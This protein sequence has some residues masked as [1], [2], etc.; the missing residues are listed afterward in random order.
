MRKWRQSKKEHWSS[1]IADNPALKQVLDAS[2]SGETV[3]ANISLGRAGRDRVNWTFTGDEELHVQKH[4]GMIVGIT[5]KNHGFADFS[6]FNDIVSESGTAKLELMAEDYIMR[7]NHL[8]PG[9]DKVNTAD[10]SSGPSE[11]DKWGFLCNEQGWNEESQIL[12]LEGFI[13]SKGLFPEFSAYA[14]RCADEENDQA[15][16]LLKR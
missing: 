9:Q 6:P 15:A 1:I 7:I 11:E 12:H 5:P 8:L 3:R 13:R 2:G 10:N 4:E 16:D 14:Q